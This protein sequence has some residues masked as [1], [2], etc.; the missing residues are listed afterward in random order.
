[1]RTARLQ[2]VCASVASTRCRSRGVPGPATPL[3]GG[4]KKILSS[5]ALNF[6]FKIDCFLNSMMKFN[7]GAHEL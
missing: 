5:T 7:I 2:T 6:E 3:A 1:M 4:K